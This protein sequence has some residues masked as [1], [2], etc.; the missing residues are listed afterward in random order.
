MTRV[1]DAVQRIAPLGAKRC[2]ADPGPPNIKLVKVPGLQRIIPLRFL[3][4]CARDTQE[5]P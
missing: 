3:L 2:T 4:R 1:P 5:A